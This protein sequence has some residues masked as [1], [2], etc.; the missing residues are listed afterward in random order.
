MLFKVVAEHPT[1]QTIKHKFLEQ[2][3][4]HLECDQ[5]LARIESSKKSTTVELECHKI[6]TYLFVR[7]KPPLK[8][9]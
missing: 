9:V 6:R 4:T 7:R 2:G 3:H 1:L 8:V 5:D